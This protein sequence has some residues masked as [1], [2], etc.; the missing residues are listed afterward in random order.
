MLAMGLLGFLLDRFEVPLGPIVLGLILGSRLEETFVQNLTKEASFTAF[1][2]RPIAAKLGAVCLLL[3]SMP[4][5]SW[6]IKRCRR[7]GS[8]SETVD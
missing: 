4:V 1:F 8:G 5:I 7:N 6:L 2:E 3:W